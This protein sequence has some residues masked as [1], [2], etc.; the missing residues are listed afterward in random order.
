MALK[1]RLLGLTAVLV[2]AATAGGTSAS[3]GLSCPGQTYGK[4]FQPWLDPANYV[5]VQ[6]GSLESSRG[7]LL[8]NGAKLVSGNEP[9][10]VNASTDSR[11]LYLPAGSSA[12][13]PA[14]CVSLLH[15][16]LRFFATNT[17]SLAATLRVEA[18]T[19]VLGVRATTPVGLLTAGSW[20]PTV[21][22]AFLTNLTAPVTGTVS[23]RFTPVGLGTGFRID[24]VYV[25][26]Y[27]MR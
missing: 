24:D 2:L 26:P 14:L 10:K 12:T 6:N 7:W 27:K 18:I 8:T 25:D 9:W 5:L 21:P 20:Q 15:P 3:A 22:L 23:F 16:T 17:G 19:D 4:P 1:L 11:S 13:S